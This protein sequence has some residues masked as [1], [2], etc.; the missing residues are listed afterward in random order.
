PQSGWSAIGDASQPKGYRFGDD[1]GPI[2]KLTV[3][4]DKLQI[5]G[6]DVAWAYT[7]DEP[8]QGAVALRLRLGTG[9]VW[10]AAAPGDPDKDEVDKFAAERNAPPPFS[11]P[12][13]RQL[14]LRAV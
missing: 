3:L 14:L 4:K 6:G 2:A 12:K 8:A 9:V 13:P 10:C 11:C 1:T 7:L 5:K